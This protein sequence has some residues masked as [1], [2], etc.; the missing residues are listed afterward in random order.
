MQYYSTDVNS[1][2]HILPYANFVTNN[3]FVLL[4]FTETHSK[5]YS[6]DM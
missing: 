5:T 2:F 6:F 3:I 1:V 4:M